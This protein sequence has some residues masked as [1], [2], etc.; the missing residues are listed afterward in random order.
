VLQRANCLLSLPYARRAV[1][2]LSVAL[3]LATGLAYSWF[4][5]QR[6]VRE[7]LNYEKGLVEIGGRALD[8]YFLGQE[9]ALAV[10][11]Q[12]M[13]GPA[14][15]AAA[16]AMLV[17]FKAAHPEFNIVALI[18]PDGQLLATS[19]RDEPESLPSLGKDP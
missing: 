12:R 19:E 11:S 4:S 6:E 8:A 18:R 3:V 15:P 13:R 5:W 10:L 16:Q 14:S 17:Q 2:G 7:Q 1:V 9:R